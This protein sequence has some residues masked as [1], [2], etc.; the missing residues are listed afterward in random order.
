VLD[1]LGSLIGTPG[2]RTWTLQA[3]TGDSVVL[4]HGS[5]PGVSAGVNWYPNV[6]DLAKK[7]TVICPDLRAWGRTEIPERHTYGCASWCEQILELLAALGIESAHFVGNSLGAKL[8]TY[9]AVHQ[10]DVVDRMVLMGGPAPGMKKT[11]GLQKV[12]SYEPDLDE[13]RRTLKTQFAYDQSIVT[14]EL[15]D[16]RFAASIQDGAQQAFE[17]AVRAIYDEIDLI[18][19]EQVRS[20]SRPTLIVHGREDLVV[21]VASAYTLVEMVPDAELHVFGRCGHWA[22]IE[23]APEFNALVAAFLSVRG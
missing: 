17:A 23:R 4:L 8:T 6:A 18:T 7:F 11:Q 9:I 2:R 5:G 16:V 19:E 12:F 13:M 10:P 20:I 15:V 1:E 14:D 21:P 3:G 22:Q